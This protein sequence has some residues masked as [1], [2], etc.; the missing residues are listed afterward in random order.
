[1][2]QTGNK[3]LDGLF[4]LDQARSATEAVLAQ[5]L[6]EG[7][8]VRTSELGIPR[9]GSARAETLNW[10][11]SGRYEIGTAPGKWQ[12]KDYPGP[13][14]TG[15]QIQP[16][17]GQFMVTANFT[18]NAAIQVKRVSSVVMGRFEAQKFFDANFVPAGQESVQ[19][20][21]FGRRVREET[22]RAMQDVFERVR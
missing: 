16:A 13:T 17:G 20:S 9:V 12:R 6:R 10:R 15:F 3:R 5:A 18:G 1:M 7:F 14:L 4:L 19:G 11:K 2:K 21:G 22:L 8:L